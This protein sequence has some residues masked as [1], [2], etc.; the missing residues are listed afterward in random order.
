M[1][2]KPDAEA[3]GCVPGGSTAAA[4]IR[5]PREPAMAKLHSSF[6]TGTSTAS[7]SR[8]ASPHRAPSL[9][10]MSYIIT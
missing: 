4:I 5:P 3:D 10:P 2:G 1:V 8:A 9:A 7:N 6:G